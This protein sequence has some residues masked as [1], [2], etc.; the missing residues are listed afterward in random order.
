MMYY[1]R[2]SENIAKK[3]LFQKNMFTC[4]ILENDGLFC[5][6]IAQS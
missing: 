4:F 6:Q 2:L 5:R 3:K 1:C